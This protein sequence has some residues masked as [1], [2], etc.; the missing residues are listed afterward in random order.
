MAFLQI[1]NVEVVGMAAAVPTAVEECVNIY[2]K[3]GGTMA[4]WLQ[5]A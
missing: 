4:L 2:K 3:W 5:Q 1:N